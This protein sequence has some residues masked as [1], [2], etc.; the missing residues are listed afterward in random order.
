ML[1]C[2]MHFMNEMAPR[3]ELIWAA[4]TAGISPAFQFKHINWRHESAFHRACTGF[5]PCNVGS[6]ALQLR[7]ARVQTEISLKQPGDEN[8]YILATKKTVTRSWKGMLPAL[9][10][11]RCCRQDYQKTA[12]PAEECWRLSRGAAIEQNYDIMRANE[13]NNSKRACTH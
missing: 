2:C 12:A 6:A 5:Y 9:V 8:G 11:T 7:D 4:L 10:E 1:P 3:L 13:K